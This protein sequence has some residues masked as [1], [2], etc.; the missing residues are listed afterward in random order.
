[1]AVSMEKVEGLVADDEATRAAGVP[2][3]WRA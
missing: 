3:H 1:M 2:G